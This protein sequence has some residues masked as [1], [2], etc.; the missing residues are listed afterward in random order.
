MTTTQLKVRALIEQLVE[1]ETGL[2]NENDLEN[3][4][5][6][7]D[8]ALN[9]I[10]GHKFARTNQFD[11]IS[12]LEGLEEKF[13]ILGGEALADALQTRIA[14]LK[15][16]TDISGPNNYAPEVLHLLLELS[17]EPLKN[18]RLE[19]LD[20]LEP[21]SPPKE[22]TWE[23]IIAD[24]P[25]E[26]EI[27]KDV[28]FGAESSDAW[29][30]DEM[31]VLPI[32]ERLRRAGE[33]AKNN[34]AKRRKRRRGDEESDEEEEYRVAGVEAFFIDGDHEGLETLKDAQYWERKTDATD[35]EVDVAL[36]GA[37]KLDDIWLVSE[38]QALREVI[39]MLLGHPCA[40]LRK[41]RENDECVVWIDPE[42]LQ[43][44]F[45]LR[46]TSLRGFDAVLEWFAEKG[47]SLNRIRA[48]TQNKEDSPERQSFVAAVDEKLAELNKELITIE[49]KYVGKGAS[50]SVSLLALQ[51][52][53][54]PMIRPFG[55]LCR[56]ITNLNTS[57]HL[58]QLYL[59]AC[60]LQ[61]TGSIPSYRF[62]ATIF[63][64][65]L[66]TYLRPIRLWMESGSIPPTGDF[67]ISQT[68]PNAE[69]E[70]GSFWHTQ[71][72]LRRTPHGSLNAPSFVHP[73][74]ERI[75]TTGKS[76]VFLKHLI[77]SSTTTSD[78]IEELNTDI[79]FEDV[80]FPGTELA[81]FSSLFL[82]AF[83]RW[84]SAR[85]HSISARLRQHLFTNCGLWR[86]LDALD[87]IFFARNGFLF[88]SLAQSIFEKLDRKAAT[89]NDRF[90]LTE[91]I[92][93][94]FSS[95]PE[96]DAQR[97]RMSMK[98]ENLFSRANKDTA[99]RKTVNSLESIEVDYRLPWPVLNIIH[100]DSFT[101]YRRLFT[102]LLQLRRARY[103]LERLN[104]TRQP[105]EA[106]TGKVFF[107][108]KQRFLWFSGVIVAYI[109]DLIL[110]PLTAAL[111]I[112]LEKAADVDS[113]IA[114]HAAFI[115]KV[116]EQCLLG[117]KLAPIH[118]GIISILNLAVK[119]CRLHAALHDE[120]FA[121][122]TPRRKRR[123][124]GRDDDSSDEDEAESAPGSPSST[125][126]TTV[127]GEDEEDEES[128]EGRY[129]RRLA[130]MKEELQGLVG[131]MKDGLRGVARAGVMPHLEM[132]AEALE[133][134]GS[135]WGE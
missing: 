65:C 28:D 50:Q 6:A 124:R 27:W 25:L 92:Q 73:V 113:M 7:R 3:F 79:T 67:L 126:V 90:L 12:R 82:A 30:G 63:F 15:D 16:L 26:G 83:N 69:V 106:H 35:K 87:L 36:G 77:P 104:R 40:L 38:L 102:F 11:V 47:T 81:P 21:P 10:K 88:E 34:N 114:T 8:Y 103:L 96:V 117:T 55:S 14:A 32:R 54:E 93:N 31:A 89:W 112:D 23:D 58:E 128:E 62:V 110:R 135:G 37:T 22:L 132:L 51:S 46:H 118:K 56:I 74:A 45:A 2:N 59:A 5:I 133:G 108:L 98:R 64:S 24:D 119:F 122:A 80:C 120:G 107:A 127:F 71:F 29:S 134:Y 18:T 94:V 1:R 60:A 76:V 68:K 105:G 91:Q 75:L 13:R 53:I 129:E 101:T 84:I 121:S 131:F 95:A 109:T 125:G 86:S 115:T 72:Q 39:F 48:F 61:S 78:N 100:N 41:G 99:G 20:L 123:G 116:R 66:R 49:E 111:K 130:N 44:R 70:L 52:Q 9:K 42:E 85:H 19:D 17:K 97:L 4:T 33:E 57:S 43:K